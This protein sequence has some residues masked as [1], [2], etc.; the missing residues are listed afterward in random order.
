[1]DHHFQTGRFCAEICVRHNANVKVAG[2]PTQKKIKKKLNEFLLQNVFY[3]RS[4]FNLNY[5]HT[6]ANL[7]C[8]LEVDD[9]YV[10]NI[11]TFSPFLH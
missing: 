10:A 4:C 6:S 8:C 7:S 9:C 3:W 5:P 2:Q 11:I 1:M